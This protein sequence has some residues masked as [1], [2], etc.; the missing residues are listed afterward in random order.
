MS[1]VSITCNFENGGCR[2]RMPCSYVVDNLC[3][4][5]SPIEWNMLTGWGKKTKK[6]LPG[7]HCWEKICLFSRR[8]MIIFQSTGEIVFVNKTRNDLTCELAHCRR[9][10]FLLI[11]TI[12]Y[13][14]FH[15]KVKKRNVREGAHSG[16]PNCYRT[17][18][19]L[20]ML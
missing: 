2:I 19:R 9:P 1:L 18:L 3:L 20:I 12:L 13:Q 14:N 4:N 5:T 17:V 11:F 6:P 15:E 7:L 10:L 8:G 16:Y